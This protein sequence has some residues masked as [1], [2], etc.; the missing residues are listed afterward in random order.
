M[1]KDK[2]FKSVTIPFKK[3]NEDVKQKIIDI[4]DQ[5]GRSKIDIVCDAVRQYEPNKINNETN[6]N[7]EEIEKIVKEILG[8]M[9]LNNMA[10]NISPY[11]NNIHPTQIETKTKG[12]LEKEN[13]NKLNNKKIDLSLLD[14]D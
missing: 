11:P 1:N 14:D 6:I 7:R 9:L 13:L 2:E 4:C 8:G 3:S 12:E 5:T 10:F